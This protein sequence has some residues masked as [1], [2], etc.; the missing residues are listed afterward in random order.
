MA[1]ICFDGETKNALTD[2]HGLFGFPIFENYAR[3]LPSLVGS[4]CTLELLVEKWDVGVCLAY[5]DLSVFNILL[6]FNLDL[7]LGELTFKVI[8]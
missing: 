3:F 2:R 4:D 6:G 5:D 7:T 1:G 8:F